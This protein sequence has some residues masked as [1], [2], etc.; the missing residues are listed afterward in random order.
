MAQN[1]GDAA[2][3]ELGREAVRSGRALRGDEPTVGDRRAKELGGGE[4][5]PVREP[6]LGERAED[7]VSGVE[8]AAVRVA[9]RASLDP[10]PVARYESS[11]F[12]MPKKP[13]NR[14][15]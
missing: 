12:R 2:A 11:F 3:G 13:R 10:G 6:A 5:L 8:D 4:R 1:S 7:D 15:Q 14:R 9:E